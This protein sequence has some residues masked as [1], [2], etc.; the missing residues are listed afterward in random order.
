MLDLFT[1]PCPVVFFL[2]N[3]RPRRPPLFP[4]PTLF[5]SS[6][7]QRAITRR[8]PLQHILDAITAGARD[9]LR[10]DAAGLYV[11]DPDNPDVDRKSTR[12]NSSHANISY[13]V[14]CLKTKKAASAAPSA[15][16]ALA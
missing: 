9:L 14:F 15:S 1:L 3:R 11:M 10:D 16:S 7:I 5:R 4:Y 13:A 8:A 6:V 12:L 2:M